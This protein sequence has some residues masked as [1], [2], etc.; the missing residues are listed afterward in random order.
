MSSTTVADTTS[1]TTSATVTDG[2]NT[3]TLTDTIEYRADK[4][5]TITAVS[6]NT[7]S[8]YGS[9]TLTLTGTNLDIGTAEILIDGIECVV[10][11][12]ATTSTNLECVT[13]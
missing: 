5:P 4:T 3:Y 13:G 7:G 8:I 6:Q 9:E 2:Q 12:G 10:N 11:G 1:F